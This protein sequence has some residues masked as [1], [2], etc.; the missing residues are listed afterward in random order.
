V[1][2]TKTRNAKKVSGKNTLAKEEEEEEEEDE[3]E[4]KRRQNSERQ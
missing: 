1:R 3:E 2:N 4:A